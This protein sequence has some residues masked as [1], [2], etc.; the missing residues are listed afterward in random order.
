[1]KVSLI[2]TTY[3]RP[4]YLRK[5]LEGVLCQNLLP[6]EILIADDGSDER[7]KQVVKKFQALKACP[8]THVWHE[9]MGFRAAKIRN[10]AIK[11]ARGDYIVFLD[12]DCI[13]AV[14]FIA[15]HVSLAK[16]GHFF[17]GKRLLV[18]KEASGSFEASS[19]GD[20]R[21]LLRLFVKGHL[22]HVH[23]LM[24][25]SFLPA[26]S[27][28]S[29]KG[30]RSCNIGIYR[31][32]LITVNGFNQDFVGWGREDSELVV[33]LYNYGLRRRSH[34]FMATCFHLWHEENPRDR[35]GENDG[36]LRAAIAAG[37][38]RCNNGIERD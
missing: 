5:V 35:L 27:G 10:E 6:D 2:I 16:E 34:P 30:V 13:P 18:A 22:S 19:A 28:R 36:L 20:V 23:H 1:L 38:Y 25:V 37:G 8:L 3:N 12:G 4:D 24:R 11:Q 32:D 33:R 31:K 9:H 26:L 21:H 15:D 7:T 14:R 17:Q 29:I